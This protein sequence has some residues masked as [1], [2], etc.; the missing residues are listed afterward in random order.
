MKKLRTYRLLPNGSDSR[1][2]ELSTYNG[3]VYV[4]SVNAFE[5]RTLATTK[6]RITTLAD[7]AGGSMESAWYIANLVSCQQRDDQRFAT[8][9]APGVVFP[10]VKRGTASF[11]VTRK[12]QSRP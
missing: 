1:L 8:I 5:A 3:E 9:V 7:N 12:S 6:F 10:P 4:G 11:G 2:W